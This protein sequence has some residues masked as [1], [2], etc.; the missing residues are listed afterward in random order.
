MDLL[1]CRQYSCNDLFVISY[2]HLEKFSKLTLL[3]V[4]E[5]KPKFETR[6]YIQYS[7]VQ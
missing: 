5:V 7:S 4:T 2:S 6:A 3:K 1:S